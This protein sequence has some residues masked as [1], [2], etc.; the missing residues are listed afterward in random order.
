MHNAA[1]T[2]PSI[3]GG[4]NRSGAVSAKTRIMRFGSLSPPGRAFHPAAR[5]LGVGGDTAVTHQTMG[6]RIHEFIRTQHGL[7]AER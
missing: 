1:P 5:T 6:T 4:L 7:P 2:E 3:S